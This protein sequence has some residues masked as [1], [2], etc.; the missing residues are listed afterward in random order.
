MVGYFNSN[1]CNDKHKTPH[2]SRANYYSNPI[3]LTNHKLL[4]ISLKEVTV[5]ASLANGNVV[6]RFNPTRMCSHGFKE[7]SKISEICKYI[8]VCFG[9]CLC[10]WMH[11]CALDMCVNLYLPFSQYSCV[12]YTFFV[13]LPVYAPIAVSLFKVNII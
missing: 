11:P 8:R 1:N 9:P 4:P 10:L 2:Y 7:C 6:Y 5:R 12:P 3:D 13:C